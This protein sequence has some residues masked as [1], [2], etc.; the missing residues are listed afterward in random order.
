MT[1]REQGK[2]A[3]VDKSSKRVEPRRIEWVKERERGVKPGEAGAKN[4]KS[5][6]NLK[7][8]LR[9]SVERASSN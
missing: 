6:Q 5:R 4:H 9:G 2:V 8:S 1:T 7:S 3:R